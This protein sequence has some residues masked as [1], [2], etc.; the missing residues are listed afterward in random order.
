MPTYTGPDTEHATVD[1]E[2]CLLSM[3]TGQEVG[4]QGLAGVDGGL[5]GVVQQ[6][7]PHSQQ[8]HP[9]G[10][11]RNIRVETLADVEQ[12]EGEYE[13]DGEGEDEG[14]P[15]AVSAVTTVRQ[16]AKAGDCEESQK[17][18]HSKYDGHIGL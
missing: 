18:S 17:R 13:D 14:S 9:D 12:E 5:A 11:G 16:L 6:D 10:F 8:Q 7:D 2:A 3:L 4:H 1:R 15:A